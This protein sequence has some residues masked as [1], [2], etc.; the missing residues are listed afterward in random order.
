MKKVE[1][2]QACQENLERNMKKLEK[3]QV[4]QENPVTT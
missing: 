4:Y 3:A 2:A 1:K